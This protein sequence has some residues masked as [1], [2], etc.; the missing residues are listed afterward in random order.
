VC[1][2]FCVLCVWTLVVV[3]QQVSAARVA[4]AI[5]PHCCQYT[6]ETDE[7]TDRQKH[8]AIAYSPALQLGLNKQKGM[9][10]KCVLIYAISVVLAFMALVNNVM[11]VTAE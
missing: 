9:N 3:F 4:D 6:L 7:Q 2:V 11:S 1:D 5:S 8:I 10:E